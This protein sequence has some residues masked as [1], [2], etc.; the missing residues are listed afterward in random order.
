M[1]DNHKNFWTSKINFYALIV[2]LVDRIFL[3]NDD[4]NQK[5][6]NSTYTL[7]FISSA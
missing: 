3:T 2:P 5:G 4:T 6:S 7:C 1:E